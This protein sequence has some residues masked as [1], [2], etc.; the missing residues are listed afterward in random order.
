MSLIFINDLFW[1]HQGEGK[2]A[3]TRALFVRM[4]KCNLSC[5]WCD[6]TFDTFEKMPTE[7]IT[8]YALS[9]SARFAVVTGGEPLMNRMTPAVVEL[10]HGLGF[11]VACETN[12]TFAPNAE[13]DFI[14]CSPKRDAQYRVHEDLY[15]RVSEFKY[16][17]DEGFDWSVLERHKNDP[18]HVR[19]SL[20]P[21]FGRFK[22]SVA[23]IIE[24]TKNNPRWLIS[25][26]THKW[27]GIP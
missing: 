14:T 16:V 27:L 12:G 19:L 24:F 15:H 20:S 5:A 13:F 25:L 21:E 8:E 23:E 2:Y 3:G 7:K 4:P 9:E 26:Q 6:T 17:I 22:E 18:E 11:Y 10:L 1:T